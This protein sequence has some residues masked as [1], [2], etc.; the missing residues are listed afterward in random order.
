MLCS[1]IDAL[2]QRYVATIDI[3]GAF[4]KAKVPDD[5]ELMVKMDGELAETFVDLNPDFK[6]DEYGVLYLRCDKALYGHIE[7]ARLF[8]DELDNSLVN[9]MGF[10]QN[11]YDPCVYNK[12][13]KDGL[14]TIRTH[15]DDL[16]VSSKTKYQIQ[17]V[18]KQLA[19][20]YKEI[21]VHEGEVHDYLGMIMEHDRETRT[22]KINMKK[23]IEDTITGITEE[24]PELILRHAATPATDNLFRTRECVE[25]ISLKQA[26]IYHSVVA[27]L[28]FVAKRAR[29]DIL[30]TVLFLATRVKN[31][32]LDNWKKLLRVLGYLQGTAEITFTLTCE[33]LDK[34]TWFIDGSYASHMDMRGQSGGVL[35]TGNCAVLFKSCKQKVNTRS[36]TEAEL[37]AVDD[38][39]PMIQWTKNFLKEQGLDLDT[40][41]KEDNRSTMLLMKNGKSSSGKRTK[42][43]DVRYFY[44]KDLLDRG[45]IKLSHCL[46]KKMIADFF[47][48]PNPRKE[49]C[50]DAKHHLECS[51]GSKIK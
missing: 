23:Y 30:L 24:E 37:I 38:M 50:A 43:L 20:I 9:R 27:K 15:V 16:K 26:K 46:S 14:V 49:I 11:Q 19:D 51:G 44:V 6:L 7:A 2:E 25:K 40:E 42:H 34:L 22:V 12:A 3:K 4:L 36:S 8:Y 32:D 33:K 17:K 45:I 39:L 21:T 47:T 28:L 35:M 41:I 29:P 1:L 18:I 5:L 31:P 13:T 48:K 10:I